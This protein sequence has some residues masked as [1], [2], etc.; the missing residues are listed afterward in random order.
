MPKVAEFGI[1]LVQLSH[2]LARPFDQRL[3]GKWYPSP[4]QKE[5]C[6]EPFQ[7][8]GGHTTHHALTFLTGFIMIRQTV[9]CFIGQR[10]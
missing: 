6:E 1:L 5:L 4:D 8:I 10:G 7:Q 2:S 3:C 9:N